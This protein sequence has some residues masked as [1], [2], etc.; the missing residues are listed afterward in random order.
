MSKYTDDLYAALGVVNAWNLS[1]KYECPIIYFHTQH[2]HAFGHSDHRAEVCFFRDGN[3][4]KKVIRTRE[5]RRLKESREAHLR[6]AI[7]W[8]EKRGLGV[9]E[10]APSGFRDIWIPKD[11][12]EKVMADLK[13]WRKTQRQAAKEATS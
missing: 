13:A 10:W 3:R 4:W 8:A 9:Q 6:A 2:A 12:K 11:V 1:K 5:H 7:E